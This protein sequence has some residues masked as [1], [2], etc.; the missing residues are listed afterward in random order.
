M[1]VVVRRRLSRALA[2]SLVAAGLVALVSA[3]MPS[4]A[5]A[6]SPQVVGTS[7][8]AGAT[9]LPGQSLLSRN[10]VYRLDMQPDGNLVMYDP[11]CVQGSPG[12]PYA[13]WA[14][15]TVGQPG[16]YLVMQTDGNLVLYS[17]SGK[18]KWATRSQGTGRANVFTVQDDSNL[19]IYS[20]R[21]AVWSS[22]FETTYAHVA[23]RRVGDLL[24]M[25]G[26]YQFGTPGNSMDTW[27]FGT[28]GDPVMWG[29][30]CWKD[31]RV[32]CDATG[33]LILQGDGNL[34][35]YQP[36]IHGGRVPEWSTNTGGMGP[37]NYLVMQN[38]GNLVLYDIWHRPLWNSK[39]NPV[40]HVH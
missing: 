39:G 11:N 16:N 9:L 36:G 19:V 22:G 27:D 40:F 14:L 5:A 35:W 31:P 28:S 37:S 25:N 18:A 26:R 13:L 1:P 15:G 21:R 7:L 23:N 33:D 4:T 34:V 32:N 2:L 10:G 12:C 38:D 29:V 8:P 6:A 24:S 3:V 17:S 30:N 20:G